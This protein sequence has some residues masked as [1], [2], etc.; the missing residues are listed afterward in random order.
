MNLKNQRSSQKPHRD[1]GSTESPFSDKYLSKQV[2]LSNTPATLE[3]RK[4]LPESTNHV[5]A[6]MTTSLDESI[7]ASAIASV[8]AQLFTAR[9]LSQ[10]LSSG[11]LISS[12]RVSVSTLRESTDRKISEQISAGQSIGE[13]SV[14]TDTASSS[15]KEMVSTDATRS[16]H[17]YLSQ[18]NTF[19]KESNLTLR[20]PEELNPEE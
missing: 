15:L 1:S 18:S 7:I 11:D 4:Q 19:A 20:C 2:E 14:S 8:G 5:L 9:N 12:D 16:H 17:C 10:N 13:E 6:A 3:I